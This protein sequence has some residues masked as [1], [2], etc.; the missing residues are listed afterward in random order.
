MPSHS[1]EAAASS[2]A[3]LRLPAGSRPPERVIHV[4]AQ[5]AS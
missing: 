5:T 2:V 3:S 4:W 1:L